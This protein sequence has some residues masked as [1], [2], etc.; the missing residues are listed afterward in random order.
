[1]GWVPGSPA[2]VTEMP[3]PS[4]VSTMRLRTSS[5]LISPPDVPL[6][7]LVCTLPNAAD[8]LRSGSVEASAFRRHGSTEPALWSHEVARRAHS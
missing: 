7:M 8:P 1:M 3:T 2:S 6:V 4:G 5:A